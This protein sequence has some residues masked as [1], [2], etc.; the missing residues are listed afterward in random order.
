M[1]NWLWRHFLQE[2]GSST[3]SSRAYN[4]FSGFGSDIGEVALIG[5]IV[6]GY[7]KVNCHVKGCL[8]IGHYMAGIYKVCRRHHPDVD[9]AG[10]TH[11]DVKDSHAAAQA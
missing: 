5:A 9:N 11:Q 10:V 7:R 3:S 1:L 8:R 2:T 6:G 4:F